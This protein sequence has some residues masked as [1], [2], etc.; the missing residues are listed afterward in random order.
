MV[1][2]RDAKMEEV[3]REM[4][5]ASAADFED[6]ERPQAKECRWCLVFGK[7]KETDSPDSPLQRGTQHC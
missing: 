1:K 2:E 3:I 7:G 4:G 6:E 5:C